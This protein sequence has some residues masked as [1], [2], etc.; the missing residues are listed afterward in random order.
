M[1]G[2]VGDRQPEP[3]SALPESTLLITLGNVVAFGLVGG[4]GAGILTFVACACVVSVFPIWGDDWT[5]VLMRML[6][7]LGLID[8]AFCGYRRSRRSTKPTEKAVSEIGATQRPLGD[9]LCSNVGHVVWAVFGLVGG[10]WIGVFR[11]GSF[12]GLLM[13][14]AITMGIRF[15]LLWLLG[16]LPSLVGFATTGRTKATWLVKRVQWTVAAARTQSVLHFLIALLALLA[17]LVVWLEFVFF[18]E[19]RSSY[20]LGVLLG[21]L[22][23][24]LV[25]L[26]SWGL[27]NR[28]A[29]ARQL[30]MAFHLIIAVAALSVMVWSMHECLTIKG[31]PDSLAGVGGVIGAIIGGIALGVFILSS[32]FLWWFWRAR[33][34]EKT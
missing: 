10:G 4:I 33:D 31:G 5:V 19:K 34:S 2:Q 29:W 14:P 26:V 9:L 20:S 7:L 15:V 32:G 25:A 30:A 8:G 1:P 17:V 11:Y 24:V 23:S 21:I 27:W 18:N 12:W 22:P 6:V 16:R 3:G 13:G 28:R